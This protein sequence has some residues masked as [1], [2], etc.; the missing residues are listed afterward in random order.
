M[1][2]RTLPRLDDRARGWLRHIWDKSTTPDDWSSS[3]EPHP[4]WDKTSTKPLCSLPRFD[5][6]ETGYVLPVMCDITPA[7]REVYTK[8]ADGLVSRYT[9]F[10][11][12]IDWLTQIGHDPNQANYPPEWL[13]LMPE[14]V[15]GRYDSPGWVANGV[16]PWGLQ[17]HPFASD[18]NHFARAF[19]NLLLCFYRYVSGDNKWEKTSKVTGYQDRQFDWDHHSMVDFMVTQWRERPQGPHCENTKIWPFCVSGAGVGLQLYD[20]IFGTKT[21]SVYD[22]WFGYAKK[23]FMAR[24][25]KGDIDWFAFYY[26]PIEEFVHTFR[27][28]AGGYCAL[29]PLLYFL[30][31]NREFTT[32]LYEWSMRK[33]GWDDPKK[34]LL[35]LHPDPRWITIAIILARDLGDSKS[36]ARMRRY[37]ADR[38]EPRFFGEQNEMFGWWFQTDEPWPRGQLSSLM[39]LTDLGDN[40]SWSRFF[41]KANLSKFHEP[42][43]SG[44]DYPAMGIAQCWNDLEEGALWVETTCPLSSNRGN[45]TTWKVSG[46]PDASAVRISLDGSEFNQWSATDAHSIELRTDIGAHHYRIST[47]YRGQRAKTIVNTASAHGGSTAPNIVVTPQSIM[48]ASQQASCCKGSCC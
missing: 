9:T 42:T 14:H 5:L 36:E 22:E 18:G 15:R 45:P 8:I 10:W 24:N 39:M 19:F 35:E 1:N 11:A 12:S 48:Q 23:H 3:G 37:V 32:Q 34:P 29:A 46:L 17:P 21:D 26:D 41:N 20:Q 6:H 33:L 4:W 13:I 44:I 43:V 27:D 47:G 16:A 38:H 40:Q 2:P 25:S 30:P 28:D 31:K 7:W